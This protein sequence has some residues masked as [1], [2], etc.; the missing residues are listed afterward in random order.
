MNPDKTHIILG[1]P[2]TGKTT[3]LLK[4]I[5]EGLAAGIQPEEICFVSFTKKSA[6]VAI[7]RAMEKFNLPQDRFPYFRTLHSLAFQQLGVNRKD[8]M[9]FGNYIDIARILGIS[10]SG[11]GVSEDGTVSGFEKG[12]R[13]LFTENLARVKMISM[14]ELWE[15]ELQDE[16]LE[17][18]EL[19]QVRDAIYNYKVERGKVDF[20]DM[21]CRFVDEECS[22]KIRWLVVDEAQDLSACQWRMVERLAAN[23]EITYIAGDD[24]QAIFRWAG[25]DV[26]HFVNLPGHAQVLGQSYR[27]PATV[28]RRANEITAK[29]TTRRQKSWEPRREEGEV[30]DDVEVEN[31]DMSQGTWLLLARNI[32]ILK[33]FENYCTAQGYFFTIQGG[34]FERA[35][36]WDAVKAWERLR[37]KKSVT[38]TQAVQIYDLM[39]VRERVAYGFKGRLQK[40][41]KEQPNGHVDLQTLRSKYG[42]LTEDIWHQALDRLPVEDREYFLSAL[43]RGEKMG[44]DPRIKISTIHGAKGGEAENVVIIPDMSFRTYLEFQKN[45]DDEARVWYVGITRALKRLYLVRPQTNRHY[46]L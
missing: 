9:G 14:R 18:K 11:R 24:D 40:M 38:Y 20:T 2:G 7:E 36:S 43:R 16:D 41:E 33:R 13:L 32:S 26:D 27:V 21:I 44:Q 37:A 23:A 4:I 19:E 15:R 29:I 42:L 1:P 12:D 31:I 35:A 8:V 6:Q 10:I 17:L 46:A 28:S 22:I 3:K 5:E 25:A 39:N 30:H 45:Q 34:G